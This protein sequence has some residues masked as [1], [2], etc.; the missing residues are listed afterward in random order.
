MTKVQDLFSNQSQKTSQKGGNVPPG[1]IEML[2]NSGEIYSPENKPDRR[3][4]KKEKETR[5]EQVFFQKAKTL[6]KEVYSQKKRETEKEIKLL[7]QTLAE[8]I[9][10]L[11]NQ[12]QKLQNEIKTAIEQPVVNPGKSDITFFEKTI[13]IIRKIGQNVEEAAIWLQAWNQKRAKKGMFWSNFTSKKGG[14]KY[15]L[16]AEQSVSR[17]AG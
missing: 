12:G 6:E 14:A 3:K 10:K 1:F 16:S 7:R 5:K 17:S 9:K 15:L 8:E 13:Q 11:K 2:K 4:E